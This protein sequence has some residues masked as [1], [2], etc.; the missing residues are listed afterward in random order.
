MSLDVI[1][2]IVTIVTCTIAVSGF[3]L[4]LHFSLSQ[5]HGTPERLEQLRVALV[6]LTET[7]ERMEQNSS[8]E[9]RAMMKGFQDIERTTS[10]DHKEMVAAIANLKEPIIQINTK[11]DQHL[12]AQ[13]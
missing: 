7:L 11:M 10:D 4:K 3:F 13:S 1:G 9:H 8:S 12:A 6:K 2:F 5:L